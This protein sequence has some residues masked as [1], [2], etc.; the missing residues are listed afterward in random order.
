MA[1]PVSIAASI[2]SLI[3][4]GTKTS[5]QLCQFIE[6]VRAAPSNIR[7]LSKELTDLCSILKRLQTAFSNTNSQGSKQHEELSA[8]F[9]N[10]LD[11]CMDKFIQL[12]L[13]VK[14]HE[15]KDGDGA[16]ARKWKGWRWTFQEKEV[17]ALK[18]Q[19]EA[20]KATLNI[21]LTMAT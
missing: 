15:I 21:T 1:D 4:V 19:L 20:H 2:A 9:E 11:S 14:A 16:L 6:D 10:V 8:D 12:Q 7:D 5:I 18:T 13:L 3:S 17:M